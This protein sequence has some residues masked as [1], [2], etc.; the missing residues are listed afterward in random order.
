MSLDA[1]ASSVQVS[2]MRVPTD[3]TSLPKNAPQFSA[4]PGMVLKT[5]KGAA[6]DGQSITRSQAQEQRRA[7]YATMSYVDGQV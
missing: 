3:L 4:S 7:Y 1:R 5:E 2:K 6:I